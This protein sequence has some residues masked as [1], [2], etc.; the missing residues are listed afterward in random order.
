MEVNKLA[1]VM[2]NSMLKMISSMMSSMKVKMNAT[3]TMNITT[4]K[5]K[6]AQT[7]KWVG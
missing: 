1:V 4:R 7:A 6:N 2:E 5:M 3:M